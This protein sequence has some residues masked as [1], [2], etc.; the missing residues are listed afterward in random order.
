MS[1]QKRQRG[2]Q[3]GVEIEPD[4]RHNFSLIARHS[5]RPASDQIMAE[6]LS[7]ALRSH[8]VEPANSCLKATID[9]GAF[10]SC[11]Q[12]FP[13]PSASWFSTESHI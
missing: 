5:L 4:S 3:Y 1:E 11:S 10:R 8:V 7:I 2:T 13:V 12:Y 9:I 6:A